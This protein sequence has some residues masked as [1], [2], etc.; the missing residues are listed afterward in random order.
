[1][2]IKNI[3]LIGV[4]DFNALDQELSPPEKMPTKYQPTTMAYN[5]KKQAFRVGE[6]LVFI[7]P[8]CKYKT[9]N[10]KKVGYSGC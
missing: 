7:N 4:V 6:T 2:E 5:Y 9:L 1:M 10:A 3:H 8:A